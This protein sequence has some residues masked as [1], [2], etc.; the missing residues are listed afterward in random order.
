[1]EILRR[2]LKAYM[3]T[4]CIFVILTFVLAAIINFT[5]FRQSW[6]FA[7]LLVALSVSCTFIGVMEGNIVGK[8][9]L[10]VG[11]A[12][13]AVLILII[14]LAVGGVFAGV[15]GMHSFNIFYIIPVIIG[16]VGGVF[17]ANLA[18]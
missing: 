10:L 9:G 8:K 4:L 5:G 12:S 14:L 16:A 18:K 1:M 17:G 7:A 13:S 6:T 11:A 3:L 2:T 15:F